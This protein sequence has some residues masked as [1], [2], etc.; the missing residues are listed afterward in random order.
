MSKPIYAI[1]GVNLYL[2]ADYYSN[3][4][5]IQANLC[6]LRRQEQKISCIRL[7]REVISFGAL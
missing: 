1:M 4:P 5:H 3:T 2:L 6:A 7:R